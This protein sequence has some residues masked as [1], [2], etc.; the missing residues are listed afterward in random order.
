MNTSAVLGF[1]LL[2]ATASGPA[3]PAIDGGAEDATTEVVARVEHFYWSSAGLDA[4]LLV[5]TS[6]RDQAVTAAQRARE[7]MTRTLQRLDENSAGSELYRLSHSDGKPVVL[8][9]DVF[10]SLA[11][12]LRVA[13]LSSGAY[14]PTAAS[15]VELWGFGSGG[16]VPDP[17]AVKTALDQVDYRALKLDAVQH[18]ATLA[19][20]KRIGLGSL[21]RGAALERATQA[22]LDA[23]LDSFVLRSGGDLVVRGQKAEQPWMV[24]VQDPRAAGYFAAFSASDGAVATASDYER[25]F[26][27]AGV[28]FHGVIDPRSGVPARSTR[29]ATVVASNAEL[30]S[31]LAHA[32]FVLGPEAGLELVGRLSGIEAIVV[33]DQNRVQ[34]SPGLVDQVRFRPPTDGP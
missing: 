18:I 17:V 21:R 12:A 32:V 26:F 3:T 20:G 28:R 22:L 4:E 30:A 5:F 19:P 6:N 2:L 34:L 11:E 23:G 13:R 27:R 24:G 10:D 29:S 25:F 1:G 8:S 14:D 31:A 15:V 16:L 33:D 7:A 9:P